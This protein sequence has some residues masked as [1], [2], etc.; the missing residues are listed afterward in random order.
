MD[1]LEFDEETEDPY[2]RFDTVPALAAEYNITPSALYGAVATGRVI[3][4]KVGGRVLVDRKDA[5]RYAKL[6][7]LYKTNA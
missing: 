3:G 4:Q 5:E 6:H 2:A 1:P 7:K